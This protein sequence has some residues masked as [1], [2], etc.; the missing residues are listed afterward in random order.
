MGPLDQESPIQEPPTNV[1]STK[2]CR[3]ERTVR[4]T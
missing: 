4:L 1:L 3:M 2:V